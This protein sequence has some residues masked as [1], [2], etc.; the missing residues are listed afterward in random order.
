MRVFAIGDLHLSFGSGVDK[1]MDVFGEAWR[2]HPAHL[3]RAWRAAVGEEDLVLIP[4]DISWAL[5]L[6]DAKPD[7]AFIGG[8]PG[9]KLL[10]RGNH[11]YWWTSLAQVRAALPPSAA[12]LQNEAAAIGG[13]AIGGTRGWTL[14]GADGAQ[15]EADARIYR[16]ELLRLDLSLSRMGPGRRIAMLHYPPLDRQCRD[17]EVTALLERYG[18]EI[19]V[20]AHL[21]G[22]AHRSAFN[23]VHNGVR[24][25]LVSSDYL[26]F[27]PLLLAEA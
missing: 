3:A 16:R 22:P 14:P 19:A 5:H 1:P 4:G 11:D 8:L 26:G 6:A 25:A 12:A 2:D 23:G 7:L 18:V 21:H 24:Y 9:R 10:L 27:S 13:F 20:Y 17:T 15:A